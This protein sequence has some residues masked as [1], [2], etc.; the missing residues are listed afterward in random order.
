[1]KW[2]GTCLKPW[3]KKYNFKGHY[4]TFEEKVHIKKI[5]KSDIDFWLRKVFRGHC[6]LFNQRH[7]VGESA[8]S[9]KCQG[10]KM[11]P[12]PVI[13]N[14]QVST[15]R[16]KCSAVIWYLSMGCLYYI[17]MSSQYVWRCYRSFFLFITTHLKI[18]PDLIDFYR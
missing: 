7:S 9:R 16:S 5:T 10:E 3:K 13:L 8:K 2:W 6:K 11:Y 1:M 12:R 18:S 14:K 4:I 15:G 17:N